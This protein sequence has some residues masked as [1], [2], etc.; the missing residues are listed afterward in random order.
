MENKYAAL[1]EM[2]RKQRMQK[3]M[4]FLMYGLLV[5]AGGGILVFAQ[6][7]NYDRP[8]VMN[9][10]TA[11][12]ESSI[13]INDKNNMRVNEL[14]VVLP[15]GNKVKVIAPEKM[16]FTKDKEVVVKQI[17][18]ESGQIKY[19]FVSFKEVKGEKASN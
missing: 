2:V 9:D 19:E 12:V 10:Y 16:T 5:V 17:V 14:K 11:T 15:T 18:M 1:D 8:K 4:R 7:K 3:V 6:Y 13:V